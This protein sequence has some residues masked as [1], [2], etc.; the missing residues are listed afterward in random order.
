MGALGAAVEHVRLIIVNDTKTCILAGKPEQC[1]ALVSH[2]GA[3]AIPIEQGMCGHCQE[4]RPFIS[5]IKE[6]HSMLR[7]PEGAAAGVTFY[8]SASQPV[9]PLSAKPGWTAG[10]LVA[11]VY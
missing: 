4:V 6:I 2:L 9:A 3:T 11:N 1:R 7:K 8:S 10:E 5:E